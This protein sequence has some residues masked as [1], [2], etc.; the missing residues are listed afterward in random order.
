[1]EVTQ[2]KKRLETLET[3]RLKHET[4]WRECFDLTYP[5]RGSGFNGNTL[6]ARQG[7]NKNAENLDSTATD[8]CRV[9]ASSIQ[10]G[11]TPANSIWFG[12][13]AGTDSDIEKHWLSTAAQTIWENIH[14]SNF[15]S[16]GYESCLDITIAGWFALYVDED[17]ING[18]YTFEQWPIA[19]V[20][21]ATSNAK[22]TIDIV[23]RKYTLTAEQAV[24]EFGENNVSEAINKAI[25]SGTPGKEFIFVH[26]IYPREMYIVGSKLAK[27]LPIAS[28]HFEYETNKE[29][30]V[31][32]Y[33]EMPVIVPR[34]MLIPAT[35]YA[36]G[37]MYDALADVR[38]LNDLKRMDKSAAEIAIAGMWIA[39]D[40]GVLNPTSIKVGPRKVIVA[41][42]VDSMKALTTGSNWQLADER[43]RQLQASIRKILMSDHLQPQDGPVISATEVHV[44][45]GLIRQLLGPIYGRMQSEY[46]QPLIERCFGIA[47]RAGVLGEAPQTLVN[48]DFHV[49]Y[50]SPLARSQKLEDVS[51]IER[52]NANIQQIF[53]VDEQVLDNIDFD[54]QARILADS[55]GVPVKTM[56]KAADVEELRKRRNEE[57]ERQQESQ[58]AATLQQEAGKAIINQAAAPKAA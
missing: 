37:P 15:D 46:L 3:L 38:E 41:N 26:A 24:K 48:R 10:A 9:L 8:S 55:L 17:R 7:S 27:N 34:W 32:G 56:R 45:V 49:K 23:M 43:I 25:Q 2:L 35:S 5:L 50:L 12:L 16:A 21:T 20:F 47:Y 19:Q 30:R 22:G 44:N 42:S 18:G 28:C 4:V 58:Q 39:E 52:F 53:A 54:E 51:S 31:S 40:D 36:V 29:V 6:D 13:D 14:M 33:H 1:M 57:I 11:V